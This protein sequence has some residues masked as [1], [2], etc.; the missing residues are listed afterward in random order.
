MIIYVMSDGTKEDKLKHI[1]RLIHIVLK[2]NLI[3][4][5]E[6]LIVMVMGQSAQKS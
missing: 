2:I 5:P 4:F 6:Y 1:F 3:V